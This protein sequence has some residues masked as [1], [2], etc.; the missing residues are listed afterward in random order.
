GED[1]VVVVPRVEDSV[2]RRDRFVHRYDR[3]IAEQRNQRG[4]HRDAVQTDE[5]RTVTL[6]YH[7]PDQAGDEIPGGRA[8]FAILTAECRNGFQYFPK[9]CVRADGEIVT[10][11][12]EVGLQ[13]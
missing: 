1:E 3:Q 4:P 10:V 9:R 11:G 8:D 12:L 13:D 6:P 2:D 5:L 7:G